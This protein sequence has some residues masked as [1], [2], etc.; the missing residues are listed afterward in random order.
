M[1]GVPVITSAVAQPV[2]ALKRAASAL[3]PVAL[4]ELYQHL[5]TLRGL[6]GKS[7]VK[8]PS[9]DEAPTIEE[10][11]LYDALA[12]TVAHTLKTKNKLPF[13]VFRRSAPVYPKFHS[14]VALVVDQHRHWF[15]K[16][17]RV[18][19]ISMLRL[20]AMLIVSHMQ[21]DRHEHGMGW[22]SIC[23]AMENLP[24]IVD[25]HFPGYAE[26]GLLQ[27]VADI[28]IKDKT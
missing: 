6:S 10:Q 20:Y 14:A 26:A 7:P 19:D 8:P 27:I 23:W 5:R 2:T 28:R 17:N 3:D 15:P 4:D 12:G 13:S 24:V 25:Q 1:S 9:R 11:T 16:L 18:Q 21:S 22:R